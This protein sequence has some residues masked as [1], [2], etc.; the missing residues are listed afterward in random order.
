MKRHQISRW[1]I[2]IFLCFLLPGKSFSQTIKPW[3]ITATGKTISNGN[4]CISYTLGEVFSGAISNK[5]SAVIGLLQP[6]KIVITSMVIPETT[7][8]SSIK[9]FP[10]PV[11]DVLEI[12]DPD[13]VIS[14]ITVYNLYGNPVLTATPGNPIYTAE[15][16]SGMYTIQAFNEENKCIYTN[17]FLKL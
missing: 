3:T 17:K 8:N 7:Y 2:I 12:S 6:E 14:K 15:L 9:T 16:G 4:I 11:N 13:E 10:N 1:L 5:Q